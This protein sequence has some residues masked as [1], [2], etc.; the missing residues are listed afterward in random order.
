MCAAFHLLLA[1]SAQIVTARAAAG[2]AAPLA[3]ALG[4]TP[5]A[6][7]APPPSPSPSPPPLFDRAR[8][9][10]FLGATA[11]PSARPAPCAALVDELLASHEAVRRATPWA[12]AAPLELQWASVLPPFCLSE[13]YGNVDGGASGTCDD[14]ETG[15]RQ[16]FVAGE[17][18][19]LSS[20]ALELVRGVDGDGDGCMSARS[21]VEA[22]NSALFGPGGALGVACDPARARAPDQALWESR[23]RGGAT[24]TGLS[25]S[26]THI[27]SHDHSLAIRVVVIVLGRR[28]AREPRPAPPLAQR[29]MHEAE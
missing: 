19:A 10:W 2:G 3:V 13:R 25:A 29:R 12:C 4:N 20:L 21:A 15:V 7:A 14:E 16:G 5:V 18:A 24:C 17:R 28:L 8:A 27:Q 23:A 9:A 1:V 11:E 22:L 26:Q 6:A